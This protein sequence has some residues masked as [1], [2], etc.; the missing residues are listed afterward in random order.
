MQAH[1]PGDHCLNSDEGLALGHQQHTLFFSVVVITVT[2]MMA[3]PGNRPTPVTKLL[4]E[5]PKVLKFYCLC[6]YIL[7]ETQ[8]DL[9]PSFSSESGH[10]DWNVGPWEKLNLEYY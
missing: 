4:C 2:T 8:F 10:H 7:K 6:F 9:T 1:Q 5:P 3:L